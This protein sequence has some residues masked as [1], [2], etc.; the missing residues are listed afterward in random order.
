MTTKRASAVRRPVATGEGPDSTLIGTSDL[1]R[2]EQLS[3]TRMI[4][5]ACSFRG[6]VHGSPAAPRRDEIDDVGLT[7]GF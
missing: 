2:G 6:L 7:T 4:L 3:V 1:V 5:V